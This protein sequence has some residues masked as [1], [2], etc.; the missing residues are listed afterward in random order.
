MRDDASVSRSAVPQTE[1]RDGTQLPQL[2]FGVFLVPPEET[3]KA[4]SLAFEAGYR[5]VD[6]ASG[7]RNEA[8]VGEAVRASGLD[9]G[10]VF[11]TTKCFNTDHGYDEARRACNASLER[12]DSG[13]IDL[14]LI[15]WPVPARDRYVDTWRAFIDLQAEGLVRSIGV[16]NFQPAHLERI[17]EETGVTPSVNQIELHPRLQQPGLRRLHDELGIATE[18]WSPLAHGHVLDDPSIVAIA[19]QH[20]RTPAQVVI[21]WHLQLGNV[22]IPKSV[23]PKRIEE[24]IDVFGF[25]LASGE[26]DA[27]GELDIAERTGPDPETFILP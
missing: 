5:H 12:L 24:N 17:V 13:P 10:E 18:A 19:D 22:V 21:R 23:T 25:E 1:L 26:M 6:T 8:E 20:Q 14:Y 2:G 9:R 15:H 4:V 7:Y 11:V 16:S 27:I 3:A